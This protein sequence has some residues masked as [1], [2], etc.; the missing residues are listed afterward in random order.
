MNRK[1]NQ[2][3]LAFFKYSGKGLENGYFDARKSGETLIGVDSSLRFFLSKEEPLLQ[4]FPF[5][6]PVKV[7]KGSWISEIPNNIESLAFVGFATW[8]AGKYGGSALSQMAKNDFE[9]IS[10]TSIF[11]SASDKLTQVIKL[12]KHLGTLAKK[13]F[14][15]VEFGENNDLVKITNEQG[16]ELWVPV[17]VLELYS[18]CPQNIFNNLTKAVDEERELI[19]GFNKENI[20]VEER[21]T[22]SHKYIFSKT[23]EDDEIVLPELKHG[24]YVELEGHITRGNEKSNTLGFL[25]DGHIVTCLPENGN[26]KDQK[27]NMFNNCRMSGLV[28]R[29]DKDGNMKEKRPRIRF[30]KIENLD[31][32]E[33]TL[34]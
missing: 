27:H 28:E 30:S 25:Y 16:E 8:M 2:E 14:D 3:S 5:D 34:F 31:K 33:P 15:K 6:I 32:D 22:L 10:I 17:E 13:K 21:I 4:E 19:V 7:T 29:L 1:E 26:I 24:D 20:T 9:N 12:A 18:E 11:I 23:E